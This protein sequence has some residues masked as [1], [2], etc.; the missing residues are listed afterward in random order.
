MGKIGL[1]V[2]G[3]NP[4]VVYATIEADEEERGF[5]RSLDD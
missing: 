4:D 2:S 3:A 1:A 5:Y